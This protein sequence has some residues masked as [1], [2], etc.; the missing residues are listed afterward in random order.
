[1]KKI[2]FWSIVV[3]FIA[4]I[5]LS[6]CQLPAAIEEGST[7][8]P[9]ASLPRSPATQ[10][11]SNAYPVP[12]QVVESPAPEIRVTSVPPTP[13]PP[14]PAAVT[15]TSAP[16][17]ATAVSPTQ[18]TA[19]QQPTAAPVQPT[20]TAGAVSGAVSGTRIQ[21]PAGGT[22]ANVQ[23]ELGG[24]QNAAYVLQASAGQTMNVTVWSPNGDVFLEI[25]GANDGRKLVEFSERA[26]SWSGSLPGTQDYALNLNAS[27]GRT[28]Y[29][30]Q[31][32]ISAL[33]G[34]TQP[35]ATAAAAS[36][37]P[38]ASAT[39][40][41]LDPN[42]A[43]G[44]PKWTDNM[45]GS[46]RSNWA[47]QQGVLPNTDNIRLSIENQRFYV[48]GKQ[49]GFM[50]WWFSWPSPKDFYLETTV[51][52]GDCSGKDAYGVIMRGP[53]HRAGKSYGYVVAFSCDGSYQMFRIDGADPFS[54]TT[55]IDWTRSEYII[56]G[57][58]QRNVIGV[59]AEGRSWTIYANG[60]KI[61]EATDGTYLEGRIGV[62]VAP[63]NTRNYTY[64]P[65]RMMY[66]ELNP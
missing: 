53:A 21:F 42:A 46:S 63:A 2:R 18:T 20:A 10:A 9:P 51:Q 24:G 56:T 52:T 19:P 14:T 30:V 4:A 22:S 59:K 57:A 61:A 26:T 58:N 37:T 41:R 32:S 17:E 65:E 5:L 8:E 66:W 3:I 36:P 11:P 33:A 64:R 31:V 39:G 7:P 45:D 49:P 40:T 43:F 15:A 38:T 25:T 35:A 34:A 13:V 28:S 55:I 50:T 12:G 16:V 44:R 62:Y 60:Y 6:A 1:M 48:T 23:G 54:S 47:D 27:G 29:T